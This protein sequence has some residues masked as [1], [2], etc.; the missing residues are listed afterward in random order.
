MKKVIREM[1][2][3]TKLSFVPTRVAQI[4]ELGGTKCW[5]GCGEM[6]A[7]VPCWWEGGLVQH[8]GE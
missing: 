2:I 5:G 6:R 4:R 8:S 3:K 7:L 1:Q